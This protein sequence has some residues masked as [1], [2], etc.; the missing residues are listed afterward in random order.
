MTMNKIT[1]PNLEVEL[2]PVVLKLKTELADFSKIIISDENDKENYDRAKKAKS[3][4]VKSRTEIKKIGL[5]IRRKFTEINKNIIAL[6]NEHVS[7]IE[8]VEEKLTEQ[9]K[10]IDKIKEKKKRLQLLPD[11]KIEVEKLGIEVDDETLLSMDSKQFSEFLIETKEQILAEKE[12]QLAEEQEKMLKEKTDERMKKLSEYDE[13]LPY[14]ELK[15]MSEGEFGIVLGNAI[16][17]FEKRKQEKV[18]EELYTYRKTL[19]S[20]M[21]GVT[22]IDRQSLLDMTE[23]EFNKFIESERERIEKE[24]EDRIK[25]QLQLQKERE[26]LESKQEQE[27]LQAKEMRKKS[28]I[29]WLKKNGVT[30]KTLENGEYKIEIDGNER[31]LYKLI[32]KIKV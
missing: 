1:V 24:R 20:V 3:S 2:A 27:Q 8:E 16:A 26:E 31:V 17:S 18:V 10:S 14:D 28:Y 5:D 6:E 25:A 4:L 9:I 12:R 23:D 11:R 13:F 7:K 30:K 22:H 15:N 19:M 21:E 32:D 29:A